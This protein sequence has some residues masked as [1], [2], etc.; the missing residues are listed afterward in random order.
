[1]VRDG[2]IDIIHK[3]LSGNGFGTGSDEL[4]RYQVFT[5]PYGCTR[6]THVSVK[7][8]RTAG[9]PF[10]R[11]KV[12]LYATS[13]NAPIGA[14]L[15]EGWIGS[16][17]GSNFE[18]HH[19]ICLCVVPP[20]AAKYAVV[21]STETLSVPSRN[22]R[23]EW[24]VA[25]VYD[26]LG[27]GKWNGSS[28]IDE[29]SL[30]N[31]WLQVCVKDAEN[32]ID[33]VHSAA[34]GFTFGQP[35]DQIKR[36]QTFYAKGT[37]PI[38]G[39]DLMLRKSSAGTASDVVVELF[40]ASGKKPIAGALA[41]AVIPASCIGTSWTIVTAPL[42]A[43]VIFEEEY[44]IVLTQRTLQTLGTYEWAT[45]LANRALAFGKLTTS[46]WIDE[47]L[48]G[49]GWLRVRTLPPT[50]SYI[51]VAP[52][53]VHGNGFGN[54]YDEIKRFETFRLPGAAS[55]VGAD[56]QIR[57]FGGANQS[58]VKA[59]LYAFNA[60][61]PSG[62]C[63]ANGIIDSPQVGD[64][65]ETV[66]ISLKS[67]ALAPGTYALILSQIS[68]SASR[69][70]WAVGLTPSTNQF[71]KWNGSSWVDESGLGNGW[72]KVWITDPD[73]TMSV[74]PSA[75]QGYGFGDT[76]AE[77]L[78]FQTF[79]TPPDFGSGVL[80][81]L[82]SL[83]LM[84]RRVNHGVE[85][86]DV[87]VQLYETLNGLPTGQPKATAVVPCS[88]IGMQWT[89][90][91]VPMVYESD[92]WWGNAL[93]PRSEYAIVVQQR[94]GVNPTWYEWA[95]GPASAGGHFGKMGASWVDE[96]ALGNAWLRAYLIK[97]GTWGTMRSMPIVRSGLGVAVSGRSLY[98]VGGYTGVS[99]LNDV[100][101]YK[102]D[103]NAWSHVASMNTP[104][105]ELAVCELNGNLWAVGGWA[106]GGSILKAL[107]IYNPNF[108]KW[109]TLAPMHTPRAGLALCALGGKL[110]A[111]GGYDGANCLNTVEVYNPD[112]NV[113]STAVAPMSVTRF[114]FAA[115]VL[116]GK[117][118][119]VGGQG[120]QGIL[121]TA[122][123]Y[124]PAL[125]RW[126]PIASMH[127]HRETH[128]VGV[129]DGK[130]Y[131]FGGTG[132][133][134]DCGGDLDLA[135]VYDPES[136][137]WSQVVSMQVPRSFLAA[138]VI[139]ENAYVVGGSQYTG[140]AHYLNTVEVFYAPSMAFSP[141]PL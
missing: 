80:Y 83:D 104:R 31:G 67:P 117:I 63:L 128:A 141:F 40:H 21:L 53:Q 64:D 30:G 139:S 102:P 118:Y 45:G 15:A 77:A 71:G 32:T 12:E 39:I 50:T 26:D 13:N 97:R 122:E 70:E 14:P 91:N 140:D 123:V 115:A 124:N 94:Y 4:K 120:P 55:I 7:L 38:A 18:V 8:R 69:Y 108:N 25:H 96:S 56:V 127:S 110:Y 114:R 129:V 84:L 41:T 17:I 90:V 106:P 85:R 72:T 138:G 35:Q 119:A 87:I 10:A 22:P 46:G 126:S 81:D 37:Q 24:A 74:T 11:P 28:W 9:D 116:N 29:S 57:R 58:D 137:M 61:Q 132:A 68:P 131:V 89:I 109:T 3:A 16:C 48:F 130:L 98:A 2:S 52:V 113:W 78:R 121:D 49:S 54:S 103:T 36:F 20:T 136:D 134:Y 19:A 1:M 82:N 107:E 100:D 135:E 66:H 23:F 34:T 62:N 133:G 75:L 92:Y 101:V 44:A 86:R 99:I 125:N 27:F 65:W 5:K 79:F 73:V 93:E 76:V 111:I 112:Y 59:E 60:G 105:D 47:T 33:V 42:H 6:I 88:K 51:A 43:G 95:V